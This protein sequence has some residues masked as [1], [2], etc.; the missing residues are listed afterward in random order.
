MLMWV[1]LHSLLLRLKTYTALLKLQRISFVISGYQ[2]NNSICKL[3]WLLR[4]LSTNIAMKNKP[5]VKLFIQIRLLLKT[6]LISM[7][8]IHD[9]KSLLWDVKCR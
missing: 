3:R 1:S 2:F 4:M 8:G 6:V 5:F 9:R 7:P